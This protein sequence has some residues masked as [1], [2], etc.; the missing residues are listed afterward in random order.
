VQADALVGKEYAPFT[1]E[2][3]KGRLRLFAKAIGETN[4]IYTDEQAARASGYA[5]LPAPPTFAFSILMDAE[6]PLKI[7][8]DLGVD[9]THT[10]HGEQSF[11][12][13]RAICAGDTITGRQ[14]VVETYEKKGGAL[15][16]VI[17]ETQL[18]NQ[19]R[20]LVA[21]LRTIIIIKQA[22]GMAV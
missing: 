4:P 15:R 21:N 22:I 14:R 11:T 20:E 17:A 1:V 6:A 2:V 19:R 10:M 18:Q 3:E 13:Y 5:A 9:K 12:Y 16:F 7:I 8:D